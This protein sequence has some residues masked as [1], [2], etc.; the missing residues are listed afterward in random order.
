MLI[1]IIL[2][3]TT[4]LIVPAYL[5]YELWKKPEA[6]KFKWLM[7][8]LYSTAFLLY[9]FLAGRWDWLSYYVRYLWILLLVLVLIISYQ[10]V[11]SLPSFAGN[12][13][14][15]WQ[16]VGGYVFT[17]LIFLGFLVMTIRG[18]FYTDEPVSLTFPLRDGWYYVAQGGNSPLINYHNSNPAQQYALDIVAL[19]AAGGRTSGIYPSDITRYVIFGKN[20]YSPCD[21]TVIE[22]IDGLPDQVPPEA[23]RE[24][25][26]GNHVI[27]TCNDV[28]VLL[29]H[30]QNG[31]IAVRVGDRV[32][33]DQLLGRVGNS[34]N[35]SE[36]HL[37]IH[38]IRGNN[39]D[40]LEGNGIPI[41][42]EEKFPVRNMLFRK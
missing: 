34:G 5:L 12:R 26:P 29:A 22:T 4:H 24:N 38:A 8:G 33:T 7:K 31:S 32:T 13:R 14:S 11:R 16:G 35:T 42:F 25:L 15:E 40:V 41:L 21:G 36:P 18:Y 37:H 27:I 3:F 17:L 28:S 23:D 20:V 30:L 2:L 1:Q 10:Q 6:S 9:I 39:L 19:N